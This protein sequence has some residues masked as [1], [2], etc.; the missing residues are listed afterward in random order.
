MKQN[1]WFVTWDRD[2]YKE[3]ASATKNGYWLVIIRKQEKNFLC[4]K[5]KLIFK[6]KGLPIFELIEEKICYNQIR[7]KKVINNW[8]KE[9]KTN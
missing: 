9:L 4:A 8:M 2:E 6:E 1:N 3:W 5:A 7:A